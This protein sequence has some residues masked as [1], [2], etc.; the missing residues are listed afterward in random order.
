MGG[1]N[2]AVK[3]KYLFHLPRGERCKK[4]RVHKGILLSIV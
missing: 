1:A 2:G 3:E 4:Y